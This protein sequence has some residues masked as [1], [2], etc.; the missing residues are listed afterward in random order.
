MAILK[1]K[2]YFMEAMHS[3]H[4]LQDLAAV[5]VVAVGDEPFSAAS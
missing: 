1:N 4:F 5:M 3:S 2:K